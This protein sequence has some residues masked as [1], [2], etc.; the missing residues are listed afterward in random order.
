M[1]PELLYKLVYITKLGLA[2]LSGW[3]VPS[4]WAIEESA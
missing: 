3:H 1:G 4:S 2:E